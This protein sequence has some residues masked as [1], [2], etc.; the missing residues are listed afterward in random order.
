MLFET[1]DLDLEDQ[2]V[3]EE[4]HDLRAALADVLRVPRRWDGLMRRSMLARAIRGSNSIEGY[5]VELDDAAAALDDEEPL[6]AD[7]QTFAEIRGYRLALGYVL[8][9][10]GDPDFSIEA[11]V[12]RGMHYMMLGHDLGKSPGR[13]RQGTIYVH[14]DATGRNVYEGPDAELVPGLMAELVVELNAGQVGDPVVGAAMAHLNL[15]M[16]HPFRDGNGRTARA[17]QTLVL[18]RGGIGEPAF[19]SIE[20]WLGSNTDD[21][22]R[23]LAATGG[24]IW[25]PDRDTGLWLKFNLRAH[26]MQAQTVA[27]R[28]AEAGRVWQDLDGLIAEHGL[29][30]RV[31]DELYDAFIGFRIRR[32]TYVNRAQV[33]QRTATRDLTRLSELGLL[34]SVGETSGRHYVAGPVLR[35]LRDGIV[36]DRAPATDPYPWLRAR[37]A[38]PAEISAD[39]Q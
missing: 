24:G 37:L 35:R 25:T 4:I 38:Q 17:L 39:S 8:A 18:S 2:Q 32:S 5:D 28:Y 21:Y 26:H 30:D 3:L 19:S 22:Y 29:P 33:E 14:D 34:S 1:P 15:V 27:R 12:L 31:T 20:E 9:S 10:V 23:V 16:I 36:A 7:E 13:Y 6:S 11:S